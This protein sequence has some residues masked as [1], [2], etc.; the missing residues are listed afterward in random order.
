[1]IAARVTRNKKARIDDGTQMLY[2]VGLL[3]VIFNLLG[4]ATAAGALM[5]CAPR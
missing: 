2:G 3:I 1:V 4:L 5:I